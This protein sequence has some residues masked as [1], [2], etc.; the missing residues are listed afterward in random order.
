MKKSIMKTMQR[1]TGLIS[2]Q[3]ITLISLVITIIILIILA[4]VAINLSIGENGIFKRVK[5]GKEQYIEAQAREKLETV[6]IEAVIEKETNENYNNKEFLDNM[7]EEKGMNVNENTVIVDNYN[8]KIDRETLKI[9]EVLGETKIKITAKVQ[10]YLGKNANEKYEASILLIVETNNNIQK[11]TI[12]NPDGTIVEMQADEVK[13]GKDIT[14]EFDKEYTVTVIT[15]D[16]KKETRKIIEKTEEIIRTA[17]ELAEFR[18]KVNTGLTYEGKII[19]LGNDIDLSS[20]CGKDINGKEINWKPIGEYKNNEAT[21]AS[22]FKGNFNG[23][24]NTIKNLYININENNNLHQYDYFGLFGCNLGTIENVKMESVKI[25]V[26]Y[27]NS[28]KANEGNI[29][30]GG[31]VCENAGNIRNIGIESG[32]I[33]IIN[34]AKSTIEYRPLAAGGVVGFDYGIPIESCYNNASI[35]AINTLEDC[36]SSI[37][38][39]N[40]V[41]GISGNSINAVWNCYNTGTIIGNNSYNNMVGGVVG[42]LQ[43]GLIGNSYNNGKI[44]AQNGTVNKA[45][46]ITGENGHIKDSIGTIKNSYCTNAS[47]QYSNYEVGN[48]KTDGIVEEG[49]LKGYSETLGA[50]FISDGKKIDESGNIVDNLDSNGNIIYI[51][52]GYPILKWQVTE[53]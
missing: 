28:L 40:M 34:R 39:T 15:E 10:E 11:V 7:L 14:V 22:S 41:G 44:T 6:L 46:G 53:R 8:F 20:V 37:R 5:I 35:T 1:G 2:N 4:G 43:Y 13:I 32:E 21:E 52:N 45:G 30:I 19:N 42:R 12:K 50:A 24:Y 48:G 36:S 17:N 3:A 9:I 23:N 29:Y 38:P 16:G 49:T 27:S 26:D 33:M 51:N 31:L 47:A 18:D 25:Y